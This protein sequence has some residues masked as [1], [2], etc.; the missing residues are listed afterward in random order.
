MKNSPIT[1]TGFLASFSENLHLLKLK[2][3]NCRKKL[4]ELADSKVPDSL[5]T[6]TPE[7]TA[8]P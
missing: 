8:G 4:D 3:S 5:V 7:V 6:L 2:S 1:R